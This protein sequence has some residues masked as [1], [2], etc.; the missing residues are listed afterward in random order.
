MTQ[1]ELKE[2]MKDAMRAKDSV[3]LGVIRGLMAACTNEAVTKGKGPDGVLDEGEMLA[4]ITRA[5][6]QRKD[7]IE[8][9]EKGGRPELA[10]GEKAELTIIMAMLPA[11]MSQDEIVAA[12]KAK[13]AELGVVDKTGANKLM[14]MLMKDLKGRADGNDVKAVVDNL[15]A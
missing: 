3:R 2:A 7:S 4:I 14:G 5:A 1:A 15:F 12:A 6:K 10:V 13:A 9:F 8:Q 11:Q